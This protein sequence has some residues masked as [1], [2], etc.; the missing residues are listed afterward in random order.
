MN[1]SMKPSVIQM[2]E[3][4]LKELVTEVK[5]T[6]AIDFESTKTK[7]PSFSIIDMW[8]IRRNANSASSML[9]R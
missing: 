2:E 4:V 7:Q 1:F 9:K 6:V 5:E 8:N 3:E